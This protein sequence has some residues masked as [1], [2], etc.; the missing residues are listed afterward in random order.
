MAKH[1]TI[2]ECARATAVSVKEFEA[3][4]MGENSPSLPQVELLGYFLDIPLEHFWG[5]KSLLEAESKARDLDIQQLLSL[6]QAMIGA[7]IQQARTR[8]G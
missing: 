4:E 8:A 2:E 7:Q 5:S 1:K 3:F 6:R